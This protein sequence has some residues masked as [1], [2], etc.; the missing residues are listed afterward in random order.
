MADLQT[1]RKVF[2]MKKRLNNQKFTA[3]QDKKR[4]SK[5]VR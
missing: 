4:V 1:I 5:M 3:V 2:V